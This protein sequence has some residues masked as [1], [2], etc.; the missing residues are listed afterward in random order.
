MANIHVD[1]SELRAFSVDLHEA[2]LNVVRKVPAVVRKGA[3][4]IKND[5]VKDASDTKWFK[6]IKGTIS[7][8]KLDQGF[9]AEIGPVKRGQGNLANIAYFGGVHGGGGTLP[10]PG[11]A[12]DRELPRFEKAIQD[13]VEEV[14]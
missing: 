4:N 2:P 8:D 14:L 5:L 7:F 3:L 10:D 6:R 13:L 1:T 9:G 12:L 11:G